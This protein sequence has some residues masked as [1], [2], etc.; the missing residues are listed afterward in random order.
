MSQPTTTPYTL[1]D[2][3]RRELYAAYRAADDGMATVFL[4]G[5]RAG[6]A[7]HA[8]W[9]RD[10]GMKPITL[11]DPGEALP[12]WYDDALVDDELHSILDSGQFKPSRPPRSIEEVPLVW[13]DTR[14]GCRHGG[15][16]EHQ[17]HGI[18]KCSKC[19]DHS[20]P[21]PEEDVQGHTLTDTAANY[22]VERDIA[23][24]GQRAFPRVSER[25]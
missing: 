13:P 12:P 10:L 21:E 1:P 5:V 17:G 7:N 9:R 2:D 19:G 25:A 16:W 6:L 4:M 8:K 14:P 11:R 22:D 18:Y 20:I 24:E 23:A 15:T 3:L